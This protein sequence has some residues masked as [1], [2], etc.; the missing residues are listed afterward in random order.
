MSRHKEERVTCDMCQYGVCPD[1]EYG[2]VCG[3]YYPAGGDD[4]GCEYGEEEYE[5]YYSEYV[6]YVAQYDE[7]LL[8][9]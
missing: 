6:R 1:R 9:E 3:W 8:Y 7:D 4:M 2:R 5:S